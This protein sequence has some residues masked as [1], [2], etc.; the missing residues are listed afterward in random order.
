MQIPRDVYS[1]FPDFEEAFM[2]LS[3]SGNPYLCIVNIYLGF[4][5][6][7]SYGNLPHIMYS[8]FTNLNVLTYKMY[9]Y[10]VQVYGHICRNTLDILIGAII[11]NIFRVF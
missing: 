4:V 10:Y 7:I 1:V 9:L 6:N 11:F 2:F 3:S 5:L 8:Q